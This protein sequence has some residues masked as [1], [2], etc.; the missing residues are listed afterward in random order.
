MLV[1]ATKSAGQPI[2]SGMYACRET[3]LEAFGAVKKP[4]ERAYSTTGQLPSETILRPWGCG[5]WAVMLAEEAAGPCGG[6]A[7]DDERFPRK[8]KIRRNRDERDRDMGA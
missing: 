2:V 5:S 8:R 6:D 3:C 1:E 7:S 4:R